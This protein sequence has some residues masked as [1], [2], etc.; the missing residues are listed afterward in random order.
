[1]DGKWQHSALLGMASRGSGILRNELYI[2]RVV[3]NRSEWIKRPGTGTRTYRLR[4]KDEWIVE[5]HPELRIISDALWNRVQARLSTKSQSGRAKYARR[6]TY[7]LTGILKC[8]HCG[9]SLTMIDQRCY[10]CGTRNR[11][12]DSACDNPVRIRRAHLEERFLQNV[13][14]QLLDD[15]TIRWAEK[16]VALRLAAPAADTKPARRE[17]ARVEGDLVRVVDAIA[18]MGSAPPWN[19]SSRN[20]KRES[21]RSWLIY[22]PPSEQSS[23]RTYQLSRPNG[24]PWSTIWETCRR[25]RRHRR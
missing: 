15:K 10:G 6:G 11:G 13:R 19:R 9:G 17:L 4:P 7:L 21:I 5:E 24:G 14:E 18:K 3:W 22:K 16:E 23:W 8:L 25:W 1:M 12:G 2:G 20:W